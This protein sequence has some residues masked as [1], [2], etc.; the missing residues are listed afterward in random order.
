MID[1]VKLKEMR[2]DAHAQLSYCCRTVME[3]GPVAEYI[4]ALEQMLHQEIATKPDRCEF[5]QDWV[6]ELNNE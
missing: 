6:E 1:K 4:R 2:E 5:T 3:L